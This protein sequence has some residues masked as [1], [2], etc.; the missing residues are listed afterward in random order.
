M[1]ETP[2][3]RQPRMPIEARR[4]QILE[5]ALR[6]ITAQGYSAAT[7]EAIAREADIAKP[8]VYA[9]YPGRE[10]LMQALLEREEARIIA[11][12]ATA[13]PALHGDID[14]EPTLT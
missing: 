6:L 12:L 3:K 10:P 11:A 7:M 14:F 2:R 8:R 13:M 9:A 4:D 5:A 1:T